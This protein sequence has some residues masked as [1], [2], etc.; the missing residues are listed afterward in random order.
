MKS[1]R[2]GATN[3][4]YTCTV[5]IIADRGLCDIHHY[6]YYIVATGIDY[7]GR[8]YGIRTGNIVASYTLYVVQYTCKSSF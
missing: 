6:Y 2:L 7:R 3:T 5:I 8:I 1:K 4:Y